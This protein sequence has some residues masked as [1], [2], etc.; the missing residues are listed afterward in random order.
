M[1]KIF[2]R[3][4]VEKI[5]G[6]RRDVDG[7]RGIAVL[8]VLIFHAFPSLLPGGFIGVD[9]FFVISGFLISRL[10]VLG[11]KADSF[12]FV[13]FYSRRIKR[14]FPALI[15][16]FS[17]CYLLGWFVL[18][19]HEY[20]QLGKHIAGGASFISNLILW[21]ESG[22]FDNTAI[23]KPLLHLWSLGIEEQF[24][25]L[26]PFALWVS[27]YKKINWFW[28]TILTITVSFSLNVWLV[29]HDPIATFY[30]PLTRAW[31]L[32]LGALVA[33]DK[34]SNCFCAL[35]A[36]V[37]SALTFAALCV[38]AIGLIFINKNDHFPGAW[39]L[40]PTLATAILLGVGPT[41]VL[42]AKLLSNQL[43]VWIGLI[44]YPLYLWHWPLLSFGRILEGE[45]LGTVALC[46][47]LVLS[48]LLAWI[49]YRFIERPLRYKTNDVVTA[50]ALVFCMAV[51]AF[52]GYNTYSREGLEFRGPQVLGKDRG[53]E[54]GPGGTLIA[55][56]GLP[57]E[58]SAGFTCWQDTRDKLRFALVG[59]SKASALH[60]GLVRT[61]SDLGRWL[62]IGMGSQGSP[63]PIITSDTR[64][65]RYQYGSTTAIKSIAENKDIDVVLIATATRAIFQLRN[66]TDIEDLEKSPNYQ[67][68]LEGLQR[69]VDI[70]RS[71][72]KKVV[73][74]VDNPTLPH[75]EDCL[76]RTTNSVV[77]NRL[78]KQTM[79]Q[80][81]QLPLEKHLQ[82]S[83]KY[84]DLLNTLVTNNPDTVSLFDSTPFL[85]DLKEK[86]CS[87]E[88]NGRLLYGDT[89]H[90]SDYAAGQIGQQLN[91]YLESIRTAK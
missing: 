64:Y 63:L 57:K 24:Y 23:T 19:P 55:E 56:C 52:V 86:L 73:F 39:A 2:S 12:T 62:F 47:I 82:L 38:L 22:Y 28:L 13:N 8:T 74:L 42:H 26:W 54:G 89:D 14:I 44:S 91:R 79:N 50:S 77:L 90:I 58:V 37:R 46:S 87:T 75:P 78:I 33:H 29:F 18:L 68:G 51:A 25:I 48:I 4:P 34:I 76:P 43:L 9:I 67:V 27:F 69:V 53:Y 72:Q 1:P 31:E 5:P 20:Q 16:V 81:C 49:T 83:R 17:C 66:D 6:Y 80:R 32:L 36:R 7:M 59:D 88:R 35:S 21:S 40:L 3:N 61:S 70:L 15:T 11:I 85:C 45:P 71:N 30:S 65:S 60:G 84:R 41:T 10:V